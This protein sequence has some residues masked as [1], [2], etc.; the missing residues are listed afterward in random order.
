M[1][2]SSITPLDMWFNQHYYHQLNH[3]EQ[4][5]HLP[6]YWVAQ[7]LLNFFKV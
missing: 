3:D 2:R 4:G 5:M 7:D 6:P 1:S